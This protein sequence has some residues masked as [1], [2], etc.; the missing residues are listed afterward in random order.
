MKTIR[1]IS[2]IL[3][4]ALLCM[5]FFAL[6][7]YSASPYAISIGGN[8]G[9]AV[10]IPASG[11]IGAVITTGQNSVNKFNDYYRFRCAENFRDVVIS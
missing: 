4:T 2:A 1:K 11:T 7:A 8:T 3:L 9:N 10:T 6:S 5:P